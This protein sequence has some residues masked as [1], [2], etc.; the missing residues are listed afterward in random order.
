[1]HIVYPSIIFPSMFDDVEEIPIPVG[2][3]LKRWINLINLVALLLTRIKFK[4]SMDT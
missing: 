4:T 3:E 2:T 1:M